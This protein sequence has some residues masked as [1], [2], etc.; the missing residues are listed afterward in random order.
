MIRLHHIA[1]IACAVAPLAQAETTTMAGNT[2]GV[3]VGIDSTKIEAAVGTK[4]WYIR[5]GEDTEADPIPPFKFDGNWS[6]TWNSE[7]PDKVDFTGDI[8]WGDHITFTD[9]GSVGGVTSQHFNGVVHAVGGTGDWDAET[10][11]MTFKYPLGERNVA[12]ASKYSESKEAKCKGEKGMKMMTNKACSAF[13]ETSPGWEGFQAKL[14]FSE[15]L[16]SFEGTIV[17][18]QFGGSGFTKSQADMTMKLSGDLT[19]Q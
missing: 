7:T 19:A 10:R 8:A 15:D 5:P 1:V 17:G 3:L 2:A 11:T 4:S 12:G 18:T 16:S 6:F 13:E 9:A 14:V